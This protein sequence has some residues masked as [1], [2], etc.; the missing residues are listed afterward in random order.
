M[1]ALRP[2][3]SFPMRWSTICACLL[4]PSLA[5]GACTPT[6][7]PNGAGDAVPREAPAPFAAELWPGEGRPHVVGRHEEVV[8]RAEPT[9]GSA[10]TAR[11][12]EPDREIPW[13]LSLV[14]TVRPGRVTVHEPLTLSV[15]PLGR[16]AR[17]TREDYYDDEG[18]IESLTL[19]PGHFEYLQARAEGTC[20]IRV[21]GLV[22]ETQACPWIGREEGDGFVVEA[23]AEV[24]WWLRVVEP[25]GGRPLGWLRVEPDAVRQL[26]RTF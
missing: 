8:L 11:R 24:E 18:R 4:G 7:P 14:R 22:Y 1:A 12:V 20:F 26:P 15:R 16:V 10:A 6:T 21:D 2:V 13:D 19:P 9:E 23:P 25:E 3:E 5:L 17:L